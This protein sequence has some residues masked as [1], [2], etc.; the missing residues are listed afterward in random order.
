MDKTSIHAHVLLTMNTENAMSY[1]ELL[2]Q[3]EWAQRLA[4]GVVVGY[5]GHLGTGRTLSPV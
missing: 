2:A 3:P 4:K 5:L 1:E